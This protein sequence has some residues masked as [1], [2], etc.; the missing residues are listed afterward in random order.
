MRRWGAAALVAILTACGVDTDAEAP[1]MDPPTEVGMCGSTEDL[2]VGLEQFI[3][4][5]KYAPLKEVVEARLQPTEA[6]PAPNPSWR[7]VVNALLSLVQQ[8]GLE[9]LGIVAQLAADPELEDQLSPL[10]VVVL[11]FVDGRL[12]GQAHYEVADATSFFITRCDTQNLLT[13][14][15]G[16]M[17]LESPS[18][19]RPWL[20][21]VLDAVTPLL[22]NPTLKPFLTSFEEGGQA[23]KPAIVSILRQIMAFMADEEF[24]IERVQTLLDSAVYPLVDAQLEADIQRLVDLMGEA[25]DPAAGVLLPLQGAMRCG[26]MYPAP[27]DVLLG[28]V[29]DLAASPEV[30]LDA[31]LEGV[32]VLKLEVVVSQLELLAEVVRVLRTDEAVQVVLRDM[33]VLLLEQPAANQVVPVLIDALEDEI[34]TELLNAVVT[35]LEGCGRG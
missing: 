1:Y 16:V 28:L 11:E 4:D 24:A 21:A 22:A 17:R 27:R 3:A 5:G 10:L 12:D 32:G 30:G 14:V 6:N 20:V 35:L 8:L 19:G 7:L 25:T 23:G 33:L 31:V 29:V 15:E 26:M 9:D 18:A 34:L 13:A 2:F